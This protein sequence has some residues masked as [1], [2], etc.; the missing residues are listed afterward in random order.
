LE[1]DDHQNEKALQKIEQRILVRLYGHAGTVQGTWDRLLMDTSANPDE[2]QALLN[3]FVC[4]LE[5]LDSELMRDLED[6]IGSKKGRGIG[7]STGS[8]P[9]V[10]SKSLHNSD[11]TS[12][13]TLPP[14]YKKSR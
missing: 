4:E 13:G 11:Y 10:P 1:P 3:A 6:L 2:D 7:E 8:H 14:A 9:R 12:D 5:S